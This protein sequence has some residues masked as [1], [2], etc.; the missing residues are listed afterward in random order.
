MY[1]S[2][3]YRPMAC[4]ICRPRACICRFWACKCRP[5]ACICRP[6]A[7]LGTPRVN[8]GIQAT[9][10]GQMGAGCIVGAGVSWKHHSAESQYSSLPEKLA[11]QVSAGQ[12]GNFVS[13]IGSLVSQFQDETKAIQIMYLLISV[14]V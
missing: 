6:G 14:T 3:I 13:A 5:W 10:H 4:I 7:D 11:S 1:V 12:Y 2:C 9:G 8:L